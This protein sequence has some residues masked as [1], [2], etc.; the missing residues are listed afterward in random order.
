MPQPTVRT[1]A[2]CS[3]GASQLTASPMVSSQPCWRP[4]LLQAPSVS[5]P[6]HSLAHEPPRAMPGLWG[7]STQTTTCFRVTSAVPVG[8]GQPGKGLEN[9]P[10]RLFKQKSVI[11]FR[12]GKGRGKNTPHGPPGLQELQSPSWVH[13]VV[14]QLWLCFK[15]CCPGKETKEAGMGPG[16]TSE[17]RGIHLVK[18]S[19]PRC[20]FYGAWQTELYDFPF[21]QPRFAWTI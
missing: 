9:Q 21:F 2:P 1:A 15:I 4:W 19:P 3:P 18:N 10:G 5:L 8:V 12:G 6:C 20:Y 17:D 14:W 16:E 13:L 7:H 11:S